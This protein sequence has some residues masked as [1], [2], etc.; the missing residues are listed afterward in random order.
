V[1][2]ERADQ[3]LF[4]VAAE[5]W[6]AELLELPFAT[7]L[8]ASERLSR[9]ADNHPVE[10]ARTWSQPELSVWVEMHR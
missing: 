7:P 8:L 5:R 9:D 4:A 10:F 1:T 6:H 2:L 3:R